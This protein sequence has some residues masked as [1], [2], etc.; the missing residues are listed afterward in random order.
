MYTRAQG[1]DFDSFKTPGWSQKEVLPLLKKLE[2]F[3]PDGDYDKDAH[4]TSGPIHVSKGSHRGSKSSED[5]FI[6]VVCEYGKKEIPDLQNLENNDGF[7]R[8]YRY[9]SP[10]GKRQDTAHR[11]VHPLL[12]DGEHPNLHLLLE[13]KVNRVL[14][15]SDNRAVGVEYAKNTDTQPTLALSTASEAQYDTVKAKKMVIVAAGALGTPQVLERSGVG[16]KSILEKLKID[17]VADLPAVGENYQDHHLLLY[18]YKTSLGPEHTLDGL[19]SGRI[20]FVQAMQEKNPL[21]GWNGIDICSKLRPTPS[22]IERMGPA[23]AARWERDFASQP[24]RPLLLLGVVSAFLADPSLVDPGQ[25]VTMG[26]YTAYPYS[27]GKIHITSKS[28]GDNTNYDFDTG[29]LSDKD[30]NDLKAQVWAYKLSRE[31]Y[32]RMPTYRGELAMGHPPFPAGSAAATTELQSDNKPAT[33]IKDIEYS[34][35]DDAVIEDWIRNNLQ[36]TWHSLGTCAM[37]PR[38]EMGVV[39]KDLNVYGVSGLKLVDLSVIPENVGA[40]TN[41]TAILVGEKA[42]E[43][44][45][46]ELGIQV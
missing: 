14:F 5:D 2:T 3:H 18:P 8:W 15:D 42:A 38:E 41:N 4:G 34:A 7:S 17:C 46:K 10:D 35:E 23:F 11:Y 22:D 27:R 6:K 25:Y 16:N 37:R 44:I 21:L 20:D 30:D 26:A 32:R 9:I 29:F 1:V 28:V 43:I 36:T 31:L 39:D 19:L 24:Q 13:T 33:E 40:N 45:G 12:Q